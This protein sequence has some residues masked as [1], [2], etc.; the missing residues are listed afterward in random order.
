MAQ[1][2][3]CLANA[4][5]NRQLERGE[6]LSQAGG[7][8]SCVSLH[9]C[10][11]QSAGGLRNTSH[12][13]SLS[14]IRPRSA[15]VGRR[16]LRFRLKKGQHSGAQSNVCSP[17]ESPMNTSSPY[18]PGVLWLVVPVNEKS[19][20]LLCVFDRQGSCLTCKQGRLE[21]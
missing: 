7:H 21:T 1:E 12:P 13:G 2:A 15:G 16:K 4:T 18:S 17:T 11:G 8:H 20:G 14:P 6:Q 9:G 3:A 5:S 19:L 10:L